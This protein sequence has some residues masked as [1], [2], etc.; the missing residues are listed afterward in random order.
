MVPGQKEIE[1]EL[2]PR[3]G[4]DVA[5]ACNGLVRESGEGDQVN[6]AL[7]L[8]ERRGPWWQTVRVHLWSARQLERPTMTLEDPTTA[9]ATP[10]LG[11]RASETQVFGTLV[12]HPLGLSDEALAS[13][14]L[15]AHVVDTPLVRAR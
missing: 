1:G 14:F 15:S 5:T 8:Y 7:V 13:S 10:V 2:T 6:R 4:G 9:G 11:Q 12:R 3:G